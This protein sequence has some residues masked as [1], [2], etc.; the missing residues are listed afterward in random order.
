MMFVFVFLTLRQTWM[1]VPM[2]M[3]TLGGLQI[4]TT[5]LKG[6]KEAYKLGF[7]S[8]RLRAPCHCDFDSFLVSFGGHGRDESSEVKSIKKERKN[9]KKRTVNMFCL[10]PC[11]AGA[12]AVLCRLLVLLGYFSFMSPIRPSVRR[13]LNMLRPFSRCPPLSL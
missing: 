6:C 10:E 5:N 13:Y 11:S 3:I 1:F 9:M 12:D 7:H 8:C 4:P 2:Y